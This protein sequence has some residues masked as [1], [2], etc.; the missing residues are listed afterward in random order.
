M[1]RATIYYKHDPHKY[2][3]YTNIHIY[4]YIQK[5]V[6]ICIQIIRYF[7]FAAYDQSITSIDPRGP[8]PRLHTHT[9]KTILDSETVCLRVYRVAKTHGMPYLH[10]LI[11]QKHLISVALLRKMTCN[12]RHPIGF[13][14]P[15]C[16]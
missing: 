10:R 3:V 1:C 7:F 11:S 14:H 16:V 13:C 5:Y 2:G 9:S 15:V 4:M 6:Y 8:P 12:L